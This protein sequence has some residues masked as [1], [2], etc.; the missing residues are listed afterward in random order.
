MKNTIYKFMASILLL[1]VANTT[2]AATNGSLSVAL[3]TDSGVCATSTFQITSSWDGTVD[4]TGSTSD[5]AG[6]IA[7]DANG[8][9]I[10][11]DWTAATVGGSTNRLTGFGNGNEI[12][13]MTARPLTIQLYDITTSP[14]GGFNLQT[15]YDNIVAQGAPLLAEITYDPA[16]DVS[17]C[18]SLPLIGVSVPTTTT[19]GLLLLISLLFGFSY[20]QRLTRQRQ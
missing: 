1:I 13:A 9:P 8:T 17:D 11:S 3:V 19:W 4:D 5:R 20:R 15:I 18:S 10:A 12:N 7:F 16:T 14:P 2:N 6:M